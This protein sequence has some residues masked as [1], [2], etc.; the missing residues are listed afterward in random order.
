MPL[1]GMREDRNLLDPKGFGN[2]SGLD[3]FLSSVL[4]EAI[5]TSRVGD[6]FAK[7]AAQK[8]G[9]SPDFRSLQDFGSLAARFCSYAYRRV[10][11]NSRNDRLSSYFLLQKCDE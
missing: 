4:C 3:K 5:S 6:C 9:G 2:P 7:C 11:W 1:G 10:V 8:L